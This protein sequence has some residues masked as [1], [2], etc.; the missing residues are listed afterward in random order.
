MV[1]PKE[2]T[3]NQK[4][5]DRAKQCLGDVRMS[6]IPKNPPEKTYRDSKT[7]L[8]CQHN[9][10]TLPTNSTSYSTQVSSRGVVNRFTLTISSTLGIG[11]PTPHPALSKDDRNS[12]SRKVP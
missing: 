2:R 3:E 10:Q 12:H 4:L 6:R 8:L 9:M 11:I 1:G 7:S 5:N